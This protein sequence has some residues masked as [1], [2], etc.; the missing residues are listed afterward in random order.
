MA[1]QRSY[2]QQSQGKTYS[3][4]TPGTAATTT[5]YLQRVNVPGSSFSAQRSIA[6]QRGYEWNGSGWSERI[7]QTTPG[8]AATPGSVTNAKLRRGEL[9]SGDLRLMLSQ[10]K[11]SLRIDPAP[12]GQVSG[13]DLPPPS[14]GS[15]DP[16]DASLAESMAG[17]RRRRST[18]AAVSINSSN[19][20][21][22]LNTL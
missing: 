22:G 7:Y 18:L 14:G 10:G 11:K 20:A 2:L 21:T 13:S 12:L 1:Y 8:T 5:S 16:M 9:A 15:Y 17:L 3:A 19:A 6:N 4:P